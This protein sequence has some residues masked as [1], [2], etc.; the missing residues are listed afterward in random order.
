MVRTRG[1]CPHTPGLASGTGGGSAANGGTGGWFWSGGGAGCFPSRRRR[2]G[3][4][5]RPRAARSFVQSGAPPCTPRPSRMDQRSP[6][7]G[8][9]TTQPGSRLSCRIRPSTTTGRPLSAVMTPTRRPP[10]T[11]PT[12]PRHRGNPSCA[13]G[14]DN[15]R[16]V[17]PPTLDPAR[18]ARRQ[19]ENES[20]PTGGSNRFAEG[21]GDQAGGRGDRA[22]LA[23]PRRVPGH[24]STALN[25]PLGT[26]PP[27]QRA[28]GTTP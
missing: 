12:G 17:A 28:P 16:R 13:D 14:G 24:P 27:P 3:N 26:L 15:A 2:K 11:R 5:R 8:E 23:C 6:T 7:R 4:P 25:D 20:W 9:A 18:S 1:R 21:D 19:S 22:R 10:L